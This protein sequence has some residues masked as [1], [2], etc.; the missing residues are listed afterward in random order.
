MHRTARWMVVAAAVLVSASA[1]AGPLALW[2]GQKQT[3]YI[4]SKIS[5]IEISNP[6]AVSA[7]K[8]PSVGMDLKATAPGVSDVTIKCKDGSVYAF[9]VHVTRGAEVY[10]TNRNE[11]EHYQWSLSSN[12][13]ASSSTPAAA[14][15]TAVAAK[16]SKKSAKREA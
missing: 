6:A 9:R 15:A 2:V 11:P 3:L 12:P 4:F 16:A 10:S 14:P 13:L 5:K 7:S 8:V 1:S